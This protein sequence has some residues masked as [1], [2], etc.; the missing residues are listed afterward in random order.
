M[1]KLAQNHEIINALRE[2]GSLEFKDKVGVLKDSSLETMEGF[3]NT[4]SQYPTIKNEF[5]N[6]LINKVV[7]SKFYSKVYNN[8]LKMFHGGELPFGTSKEQIF[9]ERCQAKNFDKYFGRK[10]PT[11]K[12]GEQEGLTPE[13]SLIGIT[14]TNVHVLYTEKNYAYKYKIT[15]SELQLKQAFFN[16]TGLSNLITQMLTRPVT[17]AN[18]DEYQNM[19]KTLFNLTEKKNFLGQ[20]IQ[21]TEMLKFRYMPSIEVDTTSPT[22]LIKKIKATSDNMTFPKTDYNMAQVE[23]WSN[24][25]DLVLFVD[26]ETKA[27]IDVDVLASAFNISKADIQHR[28]IVLDE[29]PTKVSVD[30]ETAPVEKKVLGILADKE[31]LDCY[32]IINTSRNFENAESLTI[33][34][35]L[36][37]QGSMSTALFCNAVVFYEKA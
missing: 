3:Y 24:K 18:I 10:Q 37:K 2:N 23:N 22:N 35:F 6:S 31:I 26:A 17:G 11:S 13:G 1:I 14:T 20:T 19:K 8:P 36:H 15:V 34:H 4:I 33:N 29:M 9:V 12:D 32:D 7:V 28:I 21:D 25:E 5:I 30:G 27:E 16:S